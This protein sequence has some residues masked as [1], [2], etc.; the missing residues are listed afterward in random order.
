MALGQ[1][2]KTALNET[3]T[4]ILGAQILIGFQYQSAFQPRFDGLPS[5]AQARSAVALA[6]LLTAAGLLIAPSAFHRIAEGG[7]ST[8]RVQILTGRFAAAALLP[9]AVALGIDLQVTLALT[10]GGARSGAVAAGAFT[11]TAFGVWCGWGAWMRRHW[12][13]GERAKATAERDNREAVPLQARIEQMLTE[14]RVIL[15]GAQALMGFQLVIV[16]TSAFDTLPQSLRLLHGAALLCVALSVV[17]LITP[18]A[19]HRIVWA[20]EDSE[21]LLLIGGRL[22]VAALLPLALGMTADAYLVFARIF[23]S[24]GLVVALSA[25]LLLLLLALWFGWPLA[26]RK[27]RDALSE[28]GLSGA[29]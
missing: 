25:G 7:A 21:T 3:R 23:D 15:P 9:F 24:T 5:G 8:G 20:G 4:L 18:A 16:L 26:G 2:V 22:T 28:A 13:A 19:L 1:K 12:G 17:L 11:A 14:A 6:L 10:F 29:K 27:H